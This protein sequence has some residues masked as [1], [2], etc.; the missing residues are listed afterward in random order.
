MRPL[1]LLL[2]LPAVGGCASECDDPTRIEGTWA[3]WH[4]LTNVGV[5]GGATVDEAYPS[6]EVFANGWSRWA[7]TWSKGST[8]SI[9][10]TDAAERAGAYGDP[11][12]QNFQVTMKA[13]DDNCNR[14]ALSFAS[15][16]ATVSRT[17]HVFTYVADL[18]WTGDEF[19]GTYTY[20]DTWSGNGQTGALT[21][22]VGEL[23]AARQDEGFETGFA[24]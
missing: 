6:Y 24:R 23:R 22:G 11:I 5:D 20:D 21:G 9:E 17:N 7:I 3:V 1:V 10:I 2:V 12:P 16:F 8:G 15:E 14:I 4:H 13:A 18:T 19:A